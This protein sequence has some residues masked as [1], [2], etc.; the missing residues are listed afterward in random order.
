M[1]MKPKTIKI[2][3]WIVT[4]LF[5]LG[6]ALTSIPTEAGR[7]VITTT[8]GYPP[9]LLNILLVAKVLGA[10]VLLQSTFKTIKEWAYAGF[11]IDFTGAAVS[12]IITTGDIAFIIMPL[13]FL[14]VMFASYYLWKQRLQ[15]MKI[16]K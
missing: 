1:T 6:T 12:G 4:V 7:E 13:I 9:Y 15:L 14:G 2:S 10:I 3:Y 8:L 5:A 11:A 16:N